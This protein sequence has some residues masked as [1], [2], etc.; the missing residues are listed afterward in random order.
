MAYY[1]ELLTSYQSTANDDSN[2]LVK[3]YSLLSI[4]D[5]KHIC[6]FIEAS[7]FYRY[8]LDRKDK[9]DVYIRYLLYFG[10]EYYIFRIQPGKLGHEVDLCIVDT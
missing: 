9:D 5:I 2:F 7:S 8:T 3:H 10:C 4:E 6:D 1:T